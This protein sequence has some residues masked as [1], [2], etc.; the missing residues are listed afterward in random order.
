MDKNIRH[1]GLY[2]HVPFCLHK[3]A[4]CDFCSNV[5]KDKMQKS[6]YVDALIADIAHT[7]KEL[8]S[9][10]V[11]VDSIYVGGGTPS[12]LSK[13]E[14]ALLTDTV[15]D[16][17]RVTEDAEFTFE[18]NPATLDAGKAK[19][20]YDCGVNRL[21]I[22]LQSAHDSELAALSRIHNYKDFLKSYKAARKAGFDN[23]NIDVM[24]GIPNQS[25]ASFLETLRV[26]VELEPEHI[27]MYGLRIEPGTPFAERE[28][29]LALPDEDEEYAMYREGRA[30]LTDAGYMHYEISNYAKKGYGSRHNLK[31]WRCDEYIGIGVG[32]HSFYAG[33]RYAKISDVD[34]YIGCIFSEENY[35]LTVDGDSVEEID[36]KTLECEYV[37]LALRTS[38]GVDKV[39]FEAK[40]GFDFDSKYS[41]RIREYAD[42]GFVIDTHRACM[43]TPEGMYVSNRILSDILDL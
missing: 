36:A 15:Y 43:L 20:L 42:A 9:D 30:L 16:C 14:I 17:F 29:E 21:S 38:Y 25:L 23:I 12:L 27:S 31:Y 7:G 41:E 11:V 1:I 34:R 26:A 5:P 33:K 4:Y 37:M 40:F 32:A 28:G 3:C 24:F 35:A 22:G 6:A 18:A 19:C 39:Y 13:R 10:N 2:I 8:E